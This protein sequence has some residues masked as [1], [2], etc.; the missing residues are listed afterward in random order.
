S[1]RSRHPRSVGCLTRGLSTFG[2]RLA[3]IELGAV[4]SA[5]DPHPVVP[6]PRAQPIPLV[7]SQRTVSDSNGSRASTLPSVSRPR[8]GP[9]LRFCAVSRGLML[10]GGRARRPSCHGPLRPHERCYTPALQQSSGGVYGTRSVS[11]RV[12]S[13]GGIWCRGGRGAFA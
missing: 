8:A 4:H 12:S 6:N 13:G 2:R 5:F 1:R 9:W 7:R 10:S 11:S 3:A